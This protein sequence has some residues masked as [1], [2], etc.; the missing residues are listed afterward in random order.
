ME[1]NALKK[2]IQ[3]KKWNGVPQILNTR[4]K[5]GTHKKATKKQQQKKSGPKKAYSIKQSKKK[6]KQ[7]RQNLL[8]PTS[9]P[10]TWLRKFGQS[11]A[12]CCL[13]G[14]VWRWSILAL[15]RR[16]RPSRRSLLHPDTHEGGESADGVDGRLGAGWGGG[17]RGPLAAVPHQ[18]AAGPPAEERPEPPQVLHSRRSC[19]GRLFSPLNASFSF[20]EV[21]AGAF[22]DQ[23]SPPTLPQPHGPQHYLHQVNQE[24]TSSSALTQEGTSNVR[25]EEH[26][27]CFQDQ[28]WKAIWRGKWLWLSK[29]WP[30]P[31][32][33]NRT[34]ERI[35]VQ[36]E[37]RLSEAATPLLLESYTNLFIRTLTQTTK[38]NPNPWP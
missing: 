22:H 6:T 24:Q 32:E 19:E 9:P 13:L 27:V 14:A 36:L 7:Q 21:A 23:P 34:F 18:M 20:G 33:P 35:G 16:D 5:H 10:K 37:F 15:M 17:G 28:N 12:A 25:H 11:K 31:V 3:N 26:P 8:P 4:T 1:K 38:S 30:H 2:Y 29:P